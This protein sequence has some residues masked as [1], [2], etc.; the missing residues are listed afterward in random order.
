MPT[1][2]THHSNNL[3]AQEAV[4]V[5]KSIS[6]PPPSIQHLDNAE[7]SDPVSIIKDFSWC[8]SFEA[9]DYIGI[10]F[11]CRCGPGR[12]LSDHEPASS[13][14]SPRTRPTK[15]RSPPIAALASK[16]PRCNVEGFTGQCFK[17]DYNTGIGLSNPNSSSD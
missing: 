6:T 13:P 4:T 5:Q 7:E 3:K 9:T 17:C 2:N 11:E 10:C 15:P 1:V 12:D 8:P 14:P 16:C